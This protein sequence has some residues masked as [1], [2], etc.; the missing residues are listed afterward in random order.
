VKPLGIFDSGV[1]GLTVAKAIHDTI[2]WKDILYLGDTEHMP[3]G[4]KS[5]ET[6][7]GYAK[8]ITSYLIEQDIEALV[9][10]CNTASAH[11]YPYLR[12]C[13]PDLPIIN[14][15]DP[16]VA[17]IQQKF[18]GKSISIIATRGTIQSG[19]Y[20]AKIRNCC[21]HTHVF[22]LATPLLAPLVEENLGNAAVIQ[23]IL[24]HYLN[25]P[26]I[27]S[28]DLLVLAC[29]HYP[30]LIN[31]I[32]NY[33]GDHIE[34]IDPGLL[35]AEAVAKRITDYDNSEQGQL[36]C[37]VTDYTQS[38]EQIARRIFSPDLQ[39]SNIKLPE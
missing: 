7:R 30:L 18:Q 6:I 15:V 10:A 38:F 36:T 27:H 14:M 29:T 33:L 11:A 1:G 20:P 3:Y 12:K 37:R 34:V 25:K 8:K 35:V 16:V 39:L 19:V 9:I 23:G 31:E 22:T 13:F 5:P 4:D 21:P 32:K 28:S 24:E 2:P 26:E 17:Y